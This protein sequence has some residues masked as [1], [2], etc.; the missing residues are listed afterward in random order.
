MPGVKISVSGTSERI[1]LPLEITIQ[2]NGPG[3]SEEILPFMFEPFVTGKP[4]GTGLG[5][6]LVAKMVADHGGIIECDSQPGRTRFRILLPVAPAKTPPT[7]TTIPN[8]KATP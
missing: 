4:S 5:L 3:I 2:D 8:P 1:S 6:A 7:K